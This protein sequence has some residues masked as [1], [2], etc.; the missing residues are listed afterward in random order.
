MTWRNYQ[1]VLEDRPALVLFD[2]KFG[3]QHPADVDCLAWFG[4]YARM[5]PGTSYWNPEENAELDAIE[6]SLLRLCDRVSQGEAIYCRRVDTRGI[7]EYYL[8]CPE[9]AV[10]AAVLPQC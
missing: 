2:D 4:V 8:Y 1:T 6:S 10:L 3:K 7:R 5:D 9:R